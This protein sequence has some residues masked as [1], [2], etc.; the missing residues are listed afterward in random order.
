[1]VAG[2]R[3]SLISLHY[4]TFLYSFFS[5]SQ[6]TELNLIEICDDSSWVDRSSNRLLFRRRSRRRC[7]IIH[8]RILTR[9][10]L[11]LFLLVGD[12]HV[13]EIDK[14]SP[15]VFVLCCYRRSVYSGSNS[16]RFM[17]PDVIEIPPPPPSTHNSSN[18]LKQ[19]QVY[20]TSLSSIHTYFIL[21]LIINFSF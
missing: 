9:R 18:L 6:N 1:M 20:F 10:F 21:A 3:R 17:D 11:F 16:H 8:F 12:I 19:K 13:H 7:L 2:A 4:I 5:F 14:H 15:F